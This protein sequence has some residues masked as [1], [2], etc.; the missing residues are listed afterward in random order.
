M[1]TSI[2]TYD[3]AIPILVR[4][5]ELLNTIIDKATKWAKDNG[6]DPEAFLEAHIIDDMKPFSFQLQTC[7]RTAENM[8]PLVTKPNTTADE[9]DKENLKEEEEEEEEEKEEPQTLPE[10]KSRIENTISLLRSMKREAFVEASHG[11]R[12]PVPPAYRSSFPAAVAE[13]GHIDF[14][15]LSYLQKYVVPTLFFHF[16]TAYDILRKEGLPVGKFDFL[17]VEDFEAWRM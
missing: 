15:A 1:S 8:L 6:K 17:G 5:L 12:V 9:Q 4:N 7:W 16:V 11:V 13:K 2:S 3:L 14:T 10:H